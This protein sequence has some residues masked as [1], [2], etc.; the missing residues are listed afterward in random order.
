MACKAKDGQKLR[1]MRLDNAAKIYPANTRRR[2]SSVFRLSATLKETV[3]LELLQR[4]LDETVPRFPSIC[5]RLRRGFFWYYLEQIPNAPLLEPEGSCPV[6]H[7][8]R[9]EVRKCAFRVLVYHGRIAVEF[10]HSLTDGSGGMVFL[11]TLVARYLHLKH[12][13]CVPAGD[14]IL[15]VEDAPCAEE[16]EDSF[17]RYAGAVSANRKEATA[18]KITGTPETDD[19]RNLI[20]LRL[21]TQALLDKAHSFH[22]SAT[23]FLGATMLQALMNLQKEK[24]PLLSLRKP[25]KVQIP[26]NL[27]RLFPSRTLR[28]FALYVNPEIDP[29][30]GDF[31][32]DEIC[33][34]VHHHMGMEVIPQHMRA[35]IAANVGSERLLIV[36]ILPLFIKNVALRLAFRLVGERKVCLSL[37]NLGAVTLPPEMQPYVE[38]L[39]FILG[40]PALTPINCGVISYGGT[41]CI[42]FTSS[43]R[44]PELQYHFFKVL[45]S[46]GLQAIA[47][48][49]LSAHP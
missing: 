22:V 17:Q 47:E 26:V 9:K 24:V 49:N 43:I 1:W 18:W 31:S 36:K 2:W 35:R 39:D 46:L 32:F 37:S 30:L 12:G 11:K 13:I 41:T 40:A 10:F 44:E 29:R 20:C 34:R 15:A 16:L 6:T 14:G 25:V 19:H 38:R 28:N 21:D 42:N 8:P 7:M 3:D 33:K 27:R 48:S 23:A 5:A 4:A 45:Q